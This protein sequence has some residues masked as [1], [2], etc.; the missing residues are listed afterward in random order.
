MAI[1]L[2]NKDFIEGNILHA[3]ELDEVVSKINETIPNINEALE[4]LTSK[5]NSDEINEAIATLTSLINTLNSSVSDLASTVQGAA[6]STFVTEQLNAI[7]TTVS[8][9]N[10]KVDN[11]SWNVDRRKGRIL[12]YGGE[13][14]E[15]V[16]IQQTGIIVSLEDFDPKQVFYSNVLN[17]YIYHSIGSFASANS[18]YSAFNVKDEDDNQYENDTI[19]NDENTI[20]ICN[21]GIRAGGQYHAF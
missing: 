11:M 6:T 13:L 21:S 8:E 16:T 15:A 18:Y 5:A 9:I 20:C 1:D 14:D 4:T 7:R 17:I 12:V 10:D 2:L 19:Y 3:D